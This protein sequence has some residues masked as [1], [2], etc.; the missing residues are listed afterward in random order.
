MNHK[1][2]EQSMDAERSGVRVTRDLDFPRQRV[3][4]MLTDPKKGAVSWSPEGAVSLVFELD[5]RPGG[6][7]RIHDRDQEGNV[8][9]TSGTVVEIVVPERLVVKTATTLA[10]GTAPWEALQTVLFEELSPSRTRVTVL[11]QV[12]ATGSFPGGVESLE[13]GFQ[14]GW[15][16]VLEKLR[17]AL[18]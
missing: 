14:G 15:G 3:F 13:E 5:R 6:T 16:E 12:L 8:H 1:R 11:V 2:R 9:K 18:Q 10:T 4:D 17:R 7:L